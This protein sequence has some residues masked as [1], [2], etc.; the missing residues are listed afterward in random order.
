MRPVQ[1]G[2][3]EPDPA[4]AELNADEAAAASALNGIRTEVNQVFMLEALNV[5]HSFFDLHDPA[6][7]CIVNPPAGLPSQLQCRPQQVHMRCHVCQSK[8]CGLTILSHCACT[9]GPAT[10][11]AGNSSQCM[12]QVIEEARRRR[13]VG[14]SLEARVLLHVEQPYLAEQLQHLNSLPNGAD[15]LRYT[16]IVSQVTALWGQ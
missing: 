1:A 5:M 4:W 6:D 8:T 3:R 13:L 11:A 10:S 12:R 15:P 9:Q 2:W 14:A 16:F 7:Y